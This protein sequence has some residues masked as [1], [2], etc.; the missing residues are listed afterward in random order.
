MI[1]LA[2]GVFWVTLGWGV[3]DHAK[4]IEKAAVNAG[5][6]VATNLHK[7]VRRVRRP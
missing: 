7:V 2:T 3:V 6:A 5:R 1:F 4:L